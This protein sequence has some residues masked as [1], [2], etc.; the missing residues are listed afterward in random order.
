MLRK[1]FLAL[2][3]A[4]AVAAVDGPAGALTHA[5]GGFDGVDCQAYDWPW[6][7]P[8]AY[9]IEDCWFHEGAT[10]WHVA[11]DKYTDGARHTN[12][13]TFDQFGT[14]PNTHETWNPDQIST[15]VYSVGNNMWMTYC[16]GYDNPGIGP[17]DEQYLDSSP[18]PWHDVGGVAWTS[19]GNN[20]QINNAIDTSKWANVGDG[21]FGTGYMRQ[22]FAI[23]NGPGGTDYGPSW[24]D[25]ETRYS[26]VFY[27]RLL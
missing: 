20:W 24:C 27:P 16:S 26:F 18:W 6:W 15:G 19:V 5:T 12:M 22:S 11:Q 4:V 25:N 17:W 1:L 7:L 2:T 9:Q 23:P 21:I 14:H 10:S 3:I 13:D 8:N